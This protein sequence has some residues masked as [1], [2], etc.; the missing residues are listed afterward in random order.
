MKK[1]HQVITTLMLSLIIKELAGTFSTPKGS[2]LKRSKVMIKDLEIMQT[3]INNIATW[4]YVWLSAER[5]WDYIWRVSIIQNTPTSLQW[6]LWYPWGPLSS[7]RHPHKHKWLPANSQ[8]SSLWQTRQIRLILDKTEQLAST[9]LSTH[10]T[11]VW[12]P[13]AKHLQLSFRDYVISPECFSMRAYRSVSACLCWAVSINNMFILT[14]DARVIDLRLKEK[15]NAV[16]KACIFFR[17]EWRNP[18]DCMDAS[19]WLTAPGVLHTTQPTCIHKSV[20][21]RL[22]RT[23]PD[24]HVYRCFPLHA[25]L[26]T[27]RV[28]VWKMQKRTKKFP[29]CPLSRLLSCMIYEMGGGTWL[30]CVCTRGQMRLLYVLARLRLYLSAPRSHLFSCWSCLSNVTHT[31]AP[32]EN[33]L[34]NRSFSL[35]YCGAA[36]NQTTWRQH[37]ISTSNISISPWACKQL[38]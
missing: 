30:S 5:F 14:G 36:S 9:V 22:E 26:R 4:G 10:L 2:P 25:F 13:F 18:R 33:A 19:V 29:S 7:V 11:A 35:L 37:Y 38:L 32:K 20:S 8:I 23:H 31:E 17:R 15:K 1:H 3:F 21:A 16:K 24:W 6:D 28:T 27:D 12:I 34:E